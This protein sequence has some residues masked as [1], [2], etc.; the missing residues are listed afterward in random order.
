MYIHPSRKNGKPYTSFVQIM[1][2]LWEAEKRGERLYL[3]MPRQYGRDE[4]LRMIDLCRTLMSREN[5][6]VRKS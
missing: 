3:L 1:E 4:A 6:N 2:L 5:A